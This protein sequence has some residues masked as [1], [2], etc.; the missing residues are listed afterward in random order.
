MYRIAIWS[1]LGSVALFGSAACKAKTPAAVPSND[2]AIVATVNG[3]QITR[4]Q[5]Q[6]AAEGQLS[7]V[8]S[9]IYQIKKNALDDLVEEQLIAA[10]AKKAGLS[11]EAFLKKEVDDKATKPTEQEMKQFY[12]QRKAQIGD[13]SFDEVKG[14]IEQVLSQSRAQTARQALLASLKSGAEIAVNLEPPRRTIEAGDNPTKDRLPVP[15]L[16]QVAPNAQS[17]LRHLRR[18]GPLHDKG[19]SLELP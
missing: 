15:L 10:G 11:V 5:L 9:Q 1:L 7:Q 14:Q 18:E 13:R 8:E 4:E 12:E 3:T 19:L 16:R 6:D 2:P 17:D